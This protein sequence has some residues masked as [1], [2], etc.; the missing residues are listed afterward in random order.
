M[1]IIIDWNE[2]NLPI[3]GWPET[4]RVSRVLL[5]LEGQSGGRRYWALTWSWR[6]PQHVEPTAS[7][8]WIWRLSW[9]LDHGA[10]YKGLEQ[11]FKTRGQHP[12]NKSGSR[13]LL[14][15]AIPPG[16]S[17]RLTSRPSAHPCSP[18]SSVQIHGIG[19]AALVSW[20]YRYWAQKVSKVM[21]KEEKNEFTHMFRKSVN[22]F[23]FHQG[24]EALSRYPCWQV[25]ADSSDSWQ[26]RTEGW[27]QWWGY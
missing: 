15:S 19:L 7:L 1:W 24:K 6:S 2:K 3:Q 8:T 18:M 14:T 13:R 21:K 20:M 4:E 27:Q 12:S 9:S 25:R 16:W 26:S 10:F 17:W 11:V 22:S 23:P 5:G